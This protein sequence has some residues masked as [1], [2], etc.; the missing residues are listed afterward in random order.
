MIRG[1]RNPHDEAPMGRIDCPSQDTLSDFVL[2]K[3]AVPE[4]RTV[5]QHLDV[6]PECEQQTAELDGMADG[7]VSELRRI[8]DLT[9]VLDD[10]AEVAQAQLPERIGRYRIERVLGKGGFGL[11]YLAQDDQLS[12]PVAIKVPHRALANK[13]GDAD[14]YLTEARTVANLDHSHIVPVFDVGSTE[15]FPCFIVSKFIDGTDLATILEQSRLSIHETVELVATVAEALHHAHKQGL[16]HRDIKSAN[17]LLDKSG[18]PFVA[19]FGLALREQDVG[20]GPC[21]AGTPAYMS[22]EQARG[23]GHRVDG[24]S[25]IFSLGVVFYELLVGRQPFRG[26][27]LAELLQQVTTLEPSPPRQ[28]DD[29]IPGELERICLK[30]LSK[31]S[32]ERYPTARDMA[33]DLR[34]FLA[35]QAA[36]QGS[37]SV[38]G[39][40]ASSMMRVAQP[41]ASGLTSGRPGALSATGAMP[42]SSQ[43]RFKIVP[44]GLRSF[45]AHDADFF[46]SLLPGPRDRSGLPEALRFWKTRTEETN[47]DNTFTVGLIYGP[48]G[49]GKSSLVKAGLLPCLSSEVIA[50]YLEATPVETE[51]RLLAGL[52]K[53]CPALSD[54]FSLKQ[55]LA[56]LRQGQGIPVGKKVLIVLDQFEQWLHAK[57][58]EHD[59][60]LVQALR[61]CD[62]GRVQCIVMVR[63]DFWMAV[64]RFL[65]ELEIQLVEGRNS[66]AVDLFDL[67]HAKKVLAA[68]GRAFGKLSENSHD[69]SKEQKEFLKQA[70]SGLAQ[71]GKVI[72]VR[73][74]LFAE[75]M[76]GKTWTP[77]TLKEMGG[78]EG[79][80]GAFLEETLSA[81]TAPPEHRHHQKAARGLLKALLPES[82]TDIKGHMRSHAELLEASGYGNHPGEFDDLIR[83]LDAEL[84]LITP[85]DAEDKDEGRSLKGEVRM[86]ADASDSPFTLHPSP[87][88]YYQLTH[89]YLVHSLRD[90]LTRKQRETRRG[91]A[92]LRLTERAAIWQAKPENRHLPSVLEWATIRLLTKKRN[93][94][95]PQ[96]RMIKR[97]GR[98]HVLRGLGLALLIALV[99]W[100]GIEG[101]G[102]ERAS[103][104]VASLKTA[105]TA[106]VEPIIEL[107]SRYR[108]WAQ[109][110]LVHLL[111]ESAK[112]SREHLHASLALLPVDQSQAGYLYDRLLTADPVELPVI[113]KLMRENHQV[114]VDQLWNVLNDPKTE[115]DL[116]FRAACALANVE[117]EQK[118][119]RWHAMSAFLSD[120]LVTSVVKNPAHYAPLIKTLRPISDRLVPPFCQTFRNQGKPESERSL[121]AS[122]LSDY[123]ADRPDVLA[124]LLMDATPSQF[125]ILLPTVKAVDSQAW[126]VLETELVKKPAP[127]ANEDDKDKLAQ[128]Q[129]R[130]AV[131]LVRL[132]RAEDVWTL[133]RHSAD[134]R[135][136][137]FIVNWLAPL[138]AHPRPL[139]AELDRLHNV[140]Q[141]PPENAGRG[142]PESAGRGSPESAGRGSP[143]S[144][145][146]GS[147]AIVLAENADSQSVAAPSRSVMDAI[148]FH[149]ETSMRRALILALGSYQIDGPAS[150]ECEPLIGK[151]LDLYKSDP[152]A[153]IH[154]AA[155]WTLRQWKNE[156]KLKEIDDELSKVK[157]WGQRRW[158]V[159]SL[160]QSFAVIDGPIIFMMGSPPTEPDRFDYEIPHRV[161]IP[162]RFA[163][164]TKEVT[165]SH[166][167]AFAKQNPQRTIDAPD[168]NRHS[169]DQG[170]P[171]IGFS[172][173]IATQFCNWLSEQDGLPKEEW[174]YLP[175]KDGKYAIGMTIPAD[176]LRRRGYRIP[177]EAEWEYACRS[178]TITCRYYGFS[179]D[180]FGAYARYLSNS[181]DHA[182]KCGSLRPNDLGL[183]D[184]LGNVQEWVQDE[185]QP[186][187]TGITGTTWDDIT[188]RLS[189]SGSKRLVRSGAFYYRP[190][191]IRSANRVGDA[192]G[193]RSIASGFRPAR[194][195]Y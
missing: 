82:G 19:D 79:V 7:V 72:C 74:A 118:T 111:G 76:K 38:M 12:R 97:A 191:Y 14:A 96:R 40:V 157:D 88:R 193:D 182:W 85:T 141:R 104:L 70:V 42:A 139:V 128:R 161:L 2:G 168:V 94:T 150:R 117:A 5:A 188:R 147:P 173:F 100:G 185:E 186:Y 29:H 159:N 44:K 114:P 142:S 170:G 20:K 10:P 189:V 22:P 106:D 27:T 31:R 135:L 28:N 120:S 53:R 61:Q 11:V 134:P 181:D 99:T 55:T 183:F 62:G 67:D 95:E 43:E 129:A 122:I 93:W 83:I 138:G 64:T 23:E 3:L 33:E 167:Q 123:A 124:D 175:T 54:Q 136:R 69:A 77:A 156:R 119:D 164:A 39:S 89:D 153:G 165:K 9:I 90:W 113:W 158:F 37:A 92:A 1:V 25:D 86:N 126:T 65:R 174:C 105:S 137:S 151:L 71:D 145:G 87:F 49:C 194:T 52:R 103:S 21:F 80:G 109:P 149:P 195:Y 30:A 66:G 56:A 112:T 102:T 115:P 16:V 121:V 125:A 47:A 166:W 176:I 110:R 57:K 162:R 172:W 184:M 169:P 143:E 148:L 36:S 160:G 101:Y 51:T 18:K 73:L 78:T 34:I 107:L 146:R 108:R 81:A 32:S 132:G 152:D 46:L 63:D 178:G 24:R 187:K 13:L 6:C 84:R 15:Q 180:L 179:L 98:L 8:P 171:M 140:G 35:E 163:I 48:S 116:R 41:P 154:G 45:D 50:V 91:R 58:D 26:E 131:A 177:T 59:S 192:P 144:A 60:D 190:A 130:A 127:Q 4:L 155:E 68:F 75:M 17:I 133:L